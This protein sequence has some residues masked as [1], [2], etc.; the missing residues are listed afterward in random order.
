MDELWHQSGMGFKNALQRCDMDYNGGPNVEACVWNEDEPR[1]WYK[2]KRVGSGLVDHYFKDMVQAWMQEVT[3]WTPRFD[4][5][6]LPEF[7][8]G[9]NIAVPNDQGAFQMNCKD[10]L[11]AASSGGKKEFCG[12]KVQKLIDL[13]QQ[14][15]ELEDPP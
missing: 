6:R 11:T 3:D 13:T 12:I 14:E 9:I 5:A 15:D 8:N 10:T 2:C 4:H 7:Y 1:F